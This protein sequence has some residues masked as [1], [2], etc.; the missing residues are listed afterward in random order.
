MSRRF[1]TSN[2]LR[3]G[4]WDVHFPTITRPHPAAALRRAVRDAHRQRSAGCC[5][6]VCTSGLDPEQSDRCPDTGR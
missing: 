4:M 3:I 5:R 1:R 6:I 2:L